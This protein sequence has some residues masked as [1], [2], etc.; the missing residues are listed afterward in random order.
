M[1][2]DTYRR[3]ARRLDAIPNGYPA[4]E[5]GVEVRILRKL[6]GETEARLAAEMRLSPEGV[7]E[8][9]ERAGVP[10]DEARDALRDMARRGLVRAVRGVGGLR[11]G[12]LPFVV[13]FYEGQLARLD[14]E[15][16]EL[17]EAY[18]R[19]SG[20]ALGAHAP[21]VHR[22]IP[23]QEAIPLEI[24][25]FPYESA[26]ELL[27]AA[28]SWAVGPCI[29]RLQRSLLGEACDAPLEACLWFAPVEDAFRHTTVGRAIS[30]EEALGILRVAA[31]AGLVHTTGNRREG[32]DYI[33]NCCACCC[34]V[35]RGL[36]E[37][38]HAAA[39]T[40][41][42]FHAVAHGDLCV[43]CGDCEARCHF[44]AVRVDGGVAAVS[45]ER[46][47][48]CGLCVAACPSGA[49]RL[50]RRPAFDAAAPPRDE[51]EWWARRAAERG[52]PLEDVL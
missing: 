11:F 38:G 40:R 45:E 20:F 33:C 43:G 13:G 32:L 27:G 4:T 48:G 5:S 7:G 31:D 17:V 18:F 14:R 3:L 39:L 23:V 24:E 51:A 34:G 30:R 49:L 46:C 22:V 44:R 50:E 15:L 8:I 29:C 9:A 28:R 36:V 1:E 35:L 16:A 52:I 42:A 41:S 12:L 25:V 6:F 26:A 19:E 37:G 10:E 2:D 47:V 21:S